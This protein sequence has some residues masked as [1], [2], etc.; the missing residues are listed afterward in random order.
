MNKEAIKQINA[1]IA[2]AGSIQSDE[3][4]VEFCCKAVPLLAMIG[5][6][7][8]RECLIARAAEAIGITRDSLTAEVTRERGRGIGRQHQPSRTIVD[9]LDN[10]DAT[11]NEI[12]ICMNE[13]IGALQELTEKR[14]PK[15]LRTPRTAK[16][17]RFLPVPSLMIPKKRRNCKYDNHRT[18]VF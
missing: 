10:L 6:N 16:R 11:L 12:S 5:N 17:N 13:I 7:V 8:E 14:P 4:R 3:A 1:L 15:V 2:E 18:C 9:A